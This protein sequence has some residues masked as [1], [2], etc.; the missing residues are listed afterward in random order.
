MQFP[1]EWWGRQLR[2]HSL[3]PSLDSSFCLFCYDIIAIDLVSGRRHFTVTFSLVAFFLL[4]NRLFLCEFWCLAYFRVQC[5]LETFHLDLWE[6]GVL[7]LEHAN[8]RETGKSKVSQTN[9]IIIIKSNI[10]FVWFDNK[11]ICIII[12]HKGR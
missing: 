1:K 7:C 6:N 2:G 12:V 8:V 11:T 3:L 10:L 5:L 9:L 4:N